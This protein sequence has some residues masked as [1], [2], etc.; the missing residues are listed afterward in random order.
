MEKD[1]KHHGSHCHCHHGPTAVDDRD[2]TKDMDSGS[3]SLAEALRISFGILKVIMALLVAIYIFSGVF[4][5]KTNERALI[6]R[7]GRVVADSQ[8]NKII[9]PG[10]RF[11]FPY[12]VDEVIKIPAIGTQKFAIDSFW[13]FETEK[14]KLSGKPGPAPRTLNPLKDGY[15]LTRGDTLEGQ[16]NDDYNIVHCKWQLNYN[17]KD[18]PYAFFKNIYVRPLEPGELYIDV[19]TDEIKPLLQSICEEAIVTTLVKYTIDESISNAKPLISRN[20]KEMIQDRL[21]SINS[22]I[23]VEDMQIQTLTW[24]RQVDDAFQESIIASQKAK[25]AVIDAQSYRAKTI[26]EAQGPAQEKISQAKAYKTQVAETAEANAK[27]LLSLLPEY[28]K[29]PELV[30]QRI[31]QDAIEE[32][33]DNAQEKIFVQPS[34]QGK[35]REFRVLV[36]RDPSIKQKKSES[37]DK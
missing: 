24:P 31:Y 9:G 37:E 23:Y 20:V 26:N 7:F 36:N 11:S 28:M 17:I 6:L 32:V 3:K 5:V 12:P 25:S 2:F 4:T 13:Y 30:I 1:H 8:G 21:D 29:R 27:Y 22:G 19:I 15:C 34:V 10:L 16:S 14:E 33:L 18:D 35:D